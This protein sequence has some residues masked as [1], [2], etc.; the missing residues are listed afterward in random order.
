MIDRRADFGNAV[1]SL[2]TLRIGGKNPAPGPGT[3]TFKVG[4]RFNKVNI[5]V[6]R[7]AIPINKTV[8]FTD[9]NEANALYDKVV[10]RLAAC[11]LTDEN[12]PADLEDY[13]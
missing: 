11:A 13:V 3:Y 1:V 4:L 5:G 2:S 12:P 10:T 6:A 8:Y 9:L 7:F